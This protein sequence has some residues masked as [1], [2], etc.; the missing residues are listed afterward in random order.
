[1]PNHCNNLL[2]REDGKSVLDDLTPYISQ[3]SSSPGYKDG[4]TFNFDAIIPIDE[5]GLGEHNDSW[6][7]WRVNNW[8]TK[9]CGYDGHF[10]DDQTAF[11]FDTAWSPPTPIIKKLAELTDRTFAL[12][13]LEEGMFFC[14]KYVVGPDVELD[15]HY[16]CLTQAPQELKN[17]FGY[18]PHEDNSHTSNQIK[19]NDTI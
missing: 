1:M 17:L 7:D 12:R 18:V 16:H 2:T 14:G 19:S 4:Y 6:Y 10:N 3:R 8:G 5:E 11:M 9:W 15:D 13:Y